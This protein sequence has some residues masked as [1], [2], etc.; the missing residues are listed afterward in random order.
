M[1]RALR[2]L[3]VL[4]AIENVVEG[5]VVAD[6]RFLDGFLPLLEVIDAILAVETVATLG[7]HLWVV[8]SI[9]WA[10]LSVREALA[11]QLQ[12]FA[13]LAVA[14]KCGHGGLVHDHI[15]FCLQLLGHRVDARVRLAVGLTLRWHE[16]V[17]RGGERPVHGGHLLVLFL[18]LLE[19]GRHH[20]WVVLEDGLVVL[21]ENKYIVG[22]T[23][24]GTE[25]VA[26][27]AACLAGRVACLVAAS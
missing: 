18:V 12:A 7:T 13:L 25:N 21:R 16:L 26:F 23:I 3:H 17:P 24:P 9:F 14:L 8:L 19:L 27:A 4:L 22:Q 5:L 6:Q 1:L 2:V 20:L 10:Y 15:N 11:V